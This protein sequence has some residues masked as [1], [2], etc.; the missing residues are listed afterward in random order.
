MLERF[1]IVRTSWVFGLNGG[2]FVR[3]MLRL[4]QEREALRV[5]DDQIGRPT[6]APDLAR[7][8]VDMAER[9]CCGCYHACNEGPN[10]SWY[11]FACEI[12]RAAGAG[13]KVIPVSTEAYG[14]SA[15]ERP[16]NSRLD[17]SKLAVCGL[18]PLPPWQDALRR[19]LAALQQEKNET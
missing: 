3:T 11:E 9:G 4:A 19:Y 7:L 13:T 17:T 15:A 16:R 18:T 6:Y 1:C 12:L 10:I 14:R 2:N 8:L 5:V